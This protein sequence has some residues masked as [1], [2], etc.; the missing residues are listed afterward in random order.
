MI[1][2]IAAVFLA[3]WCWIRLFTR[4]PERT[5]RD[6]YPFFRLIEYG[7]L[8]ESLD[9]EPEESFKTTHSATEF[10]KWQEKRIHLAIYLCLDISANSHVLQSWA[11]YERRHNWTE[12]PAEV[13]E[14]LR[15][16]QINCMQS[17]TAAFAVRVRLRL[18][19]LRMN[20]LPMLPVPS[21]AALDSHSRTLMNFYG[22][23]EILAEE[24]SS[25]YSEEVHDNMRAVLGML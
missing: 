12:L 6:V 9:P 18:W 13:R 21:F 15:E 17:R 23:A 14:D 25:I 19:L 16:F 2:A 4:F 1:C 5:V 8:K 7:Y 10:R 11:R 24:I 22:M 20:M 3:V